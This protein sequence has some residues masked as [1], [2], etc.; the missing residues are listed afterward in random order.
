MLLRYNFSTALLFCNLY[1]VPQFVLQSWFTYAVC[2]P[3][4]LFVRFRYLRNLVGLTRSGFN[5]LKWAGNVTW[6]WVYEKLLLGFGSSIYDVC[7]LLLQSAIYLH[8]LKYMM[9]SA[10]L[11]SAKTVGSRIIEENE[12]WKSLANLPFSP[13]TWNLLYFW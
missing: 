11:M 8:F 3:L 2:F 6:K 12:N 7:N 9:K 10:E 13:G 4:D 1:N 5:P